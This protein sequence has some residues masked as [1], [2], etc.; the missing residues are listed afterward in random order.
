MDNIRIRNYRCFDD[1]GIIDIK[2]ITVLVGAN[3]SG[4]SSFLKFL[5]LIKQSVS[6]FVRG[7]F[8]W[9]GP[10]IDFND[11]DNVVKDRDKPIEVDFDIKNLP[12]YTDFKMFRGQVSDVHLHLEIGKDDPEREYDILQKMI[13]SFD[14]NVLGL[15]FNPDRSAYIV[16]NGIRSIEIG[17]V[18]KWGLT[19]SLFPKIAFMSNKEGFN[20]ERSFKIFKRMQDVIKNAS[21]KEVRHVFFMPRYR[22]S[23]DK[24]LLKKNIGRQANG[25]LSEADIETMSNM[26]MYFSINTFL[27]SLNFYMLHLCKK[28]TYVMPL[29]AIVQ[30]YYRYNNYA[31]D[32]ID[33]DGGNLP[34][35][36]NGLSPELEAMKVK[37]HELGLE[38]SI[39]LD[40]WINH[41]D[42][43][44][45]V[46]KSLFYISTALYEGLPLAVIEAMANGKAIIASD[47]VGNK[48]CVRNG[49]NGYLLPLDTDAY[50]D[51]I[52][53]LV[54]DKELRTSMEKISRALFLEEFFIENRIKYLQ[55]Q[56]NMAYNLRYVGA[57]L[58][59]QKTNIDTVIQVSI[60]YDATLYSEERRVAV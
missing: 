21:I 29:R 40:S 26:A 37:M 18:I 44:E 28:M 49:E 60:G 23:F 4:K 43:Q 42:C 20:D 30:R 57:S 25:K 2:P 35:F 17:D 14:G 47:V 7:F 31:V 39:R 34:M 58:V 56:Y 41:A 45:F 54:N 33:A 12:I 9:Q 6:E 53:Q 11:F 55:N 19:N 24:S 32:S 5:G 13:I 50:A 1:T 36:F 27:D 22:Y 46:R 52:I 8:L 59:L 15:N 38:D 51:K 10:L 16:I 48:D 3:S